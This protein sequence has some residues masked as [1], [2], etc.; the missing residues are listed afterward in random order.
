MWL[1]QKLNEFKSKHVYIYTLMKAN[2]VACKEFFIMN[3]DTKTDYFKDHFVMM[4]ANDESWLEDPDTI[5]RLLEKSERLRKLFLE[6]DQM[7]EV[8]EIA[9]SFLSL[10]DSVEKVAMATKLPIEI[11]RSLV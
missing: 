8:K 11:V 1:K 2:K 5:E 7:Q 9:R 10:G 3:E 6:R 4:L